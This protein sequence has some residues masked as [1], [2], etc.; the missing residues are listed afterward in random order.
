MQSD[1]RLLAELALNAISKGGAGF[2]GTPRWPA[3][4]ERIRR[5]RLA[6]N[7]SDTAVAQKANMSLH[8]YWDLEHYDDEAFTAVSLRTLVRVCVVLGI[9]PTG[10]LIGDEFKKHEQTTSFA[11][12]AG[13]LG[14]L[15]KQDHVSADEFGERIGWDVRDIITDPNAIWD[16]NVDALYDICKALGLDWVSAIPDRSATPR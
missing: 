13:R 14:N 8:S 2:G 1:D 3:A 9:E 11:S 15:L 10:A 4:A 6:V 5:A 12:I 16:Y 7:Q